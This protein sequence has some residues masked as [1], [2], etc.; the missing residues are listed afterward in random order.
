ME[1]P[2]ISRS[3]RLILMQPMRAIL[4]DALSNWLRRELDPPSASTVNATANEDRCGQDKDMT[5]DG[6]DRPATGSDITVVEDPPNN[7][8]PES[9][10]PIESKRP[11]L[12]S[13]H[14]RR[15]PASLW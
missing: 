8:P 11:S 2:F 14:S 10:K 6:E 15:S 3:H 7:T 1:I 4:K 5:S 9:S 12:L 13:C